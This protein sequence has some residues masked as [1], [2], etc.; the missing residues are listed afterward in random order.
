MPRLLFLDWLRGCF[1]VLVIIFHAWSHLLFWNGALIAREEVTTLILVLFA[2]L[3]LLGTWAPIFALIS[4]VA[5]AYVFHGVLSR[6]SERAPAL[7]K[8]VRGLYINSALLYLCSL[9]HMGFLHYRMNWGGEMRHSVITGSIERGR[10]APGS[11]EFLFFTDAIA[12]MAMAGAVAAALLGLLW[13]GAGFDQARRNYAILVGLGVA[14]FAVAPFLHAAFLPTFFEAVNHGHYATAA[15]LK[16]L[17]GPPH[18]TFPNVGFALFGMILGIALAR[19]EPL[20]HIRRFGYG[21]GLT[22]VAVGLGVFAIQG[23]N[24]TPD[25]IGTSLPVQLHII[26]LGLM[27]MLATWLIGYLEYQPAG[28]RLEL[29]R[30]ST[31]P[32]RFGL[33][34]MTA[35]ICESFFCA[36]Q[37]TWFLPLFDG[38]AL[39][40]RWAGLFLFAGM[41]L[42]FWYGVLRVW[43]RYDFRY[44]FEW[45]VVSVGGRL[46]GRPSNRL[47]VATILYAPVPAEAASPAS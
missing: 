1:I 36:I 19:R 41:Q 33:M 4:G 35:Y 39:P 22:A 15:V 43:E 10:W 11:V 42:A 3:I 17:V 8:H 45:W 40:V 14:W 25:R 28:R 18:S 7:R 16:L 29:A 26:N 30:K 23:V 24:L 34:A 20:A 37:L 38:S 5:T 6:A 32:R 21:T 31:W 13:R 27:L 2:P 9:I 46:R 47:D 12:L 44:S